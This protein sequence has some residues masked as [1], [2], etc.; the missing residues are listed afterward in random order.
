MHILALAAILA[1]MQI[2]FSI[3]N[4][5]V[6]SHSEKEYERNHNDAIC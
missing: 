1:A 4:L 3:K 2:L 5:V 6:Q